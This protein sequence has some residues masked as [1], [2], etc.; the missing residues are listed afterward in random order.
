[1]MAYWEATSPSTERVS[2][3]T[4]DRFPT[5]PGRQQQPQNGQKDK[6]QGKK[7]SKEWRRP[8]SVSRQPDIVSA[9]EKV[10]KK[11]T[12]EEETNKHFDAVRNITSARDTVFLYG[13]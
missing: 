6:G 9:S 8:P 3:R 5:R 12:E 11:K 1:V 2:C 13:Q 10:K 7:R 4:G